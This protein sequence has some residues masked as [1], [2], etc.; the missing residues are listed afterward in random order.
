M[1][2][3]PTT[4]VT[5]DKVTA[6]K[7]N[8][9][10]QGI[11]TGG[12]IINVTIEEESPYMTLTM[13]KTWDEIYNAASVGSLIQVVTPYVDFEG[14][15]VIGFQYLFLNAVYHYSAFEDEYKVNVGN[16]MEFNATSRNGYPE[17]QMD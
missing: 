11:A 6:T 9:I 7:M 15:D 2:Y 1:S 10:E 14:V 17:Y 3:E 8:K 16:N 13:D 4:W 12:F 5:G